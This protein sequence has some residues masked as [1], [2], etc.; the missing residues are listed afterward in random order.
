MEH[1]YGSS[2]KNP[3][4]LAKSPPGEEVEMIPEPTGPDLKGELHVEPEL[5]AAWLDVGAHPCA[6]ALR[7]HAAESL[8]DEARGSE[9]GDRS[10]EFLYRS[11]C[12]EACPSTPRP[13]WTLKLLPS[14]CAV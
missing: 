3:E 14:T 5:F 1:V 9:L 11:M 10:S 4:N 2:K 8:Q 12:G 7:Y 13:N 6:M